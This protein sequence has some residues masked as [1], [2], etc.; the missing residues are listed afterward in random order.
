[1][2]SRRP[3]RR[4]SNAGLGLVALAVAIIVASA[5]LAPVA[6]AAPTPQASAW[7]NIE[8]TARGQT[9]SLWMWGGDPQGNA[10][11]D[12]V[13]T[14]AAAKLGVTLA[15]VP[16]ADTKDALNR[17]LAEHQAGRTDGSVDLIWV[18]GDNFRTGV[19]AGIWKCG[20]AD[21]LPNIAYTA[22]G[23]PLLASDFGTPVRGCESPWHKAQFT[24][25]YNAAR[26]ANPPTTMPALMTWVREHP[27]R[28][29]YPAP[30]DFTG[31]V[32]MREALYATSGGYANVPASFTQS[33]YDRLTPALWTTLKRLRPALWRAGQTYPKDSTQL[34]QLFASGQVDFTMTYGPATLTAL[35][36]KGTFPRT[37]KVLTLKEGTVGNASFLAIPTTSAH[38]AAAQVVA[39]LA[40]SPEQ[41][42]IKADPRA[43][44]QFTVL[45]VKHLPPAQAQAFAN[46]PKSN[47]VPTYPVLAR[48]ANPELSAS[49]IP[50]LDDGWRRQV[51]T[52]GE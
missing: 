15:R 28:F 10:Y 44:G 27:G 25:A 48:H 20:W 18:N 45:D 43:W 9:V 34:D 52:G 38:F 42:A 4:L 16:I 46:L 14:A 37:T 35:V 12:N 31:S 22:P 40:L 2:R 8:R 5:T 11:V 19:Q 7:A 49:W 51:L 36:A 21:A 13:L 41:Q 23:D 24:F 39:N 26:V 3:R 47:V 6:F 17:V 1:M 50:K 29:T 33:A 32:F 30:P